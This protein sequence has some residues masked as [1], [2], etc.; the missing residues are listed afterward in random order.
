MR[1]KLALRGP[2]NAWG[3]ERNALASERTSVGRKKGQ[4]P[5]SLKVVAG[6]HVSPHPRHIQR[7]E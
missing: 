7:L 5:L 1:I 3:S 4:K 6:S 2:D